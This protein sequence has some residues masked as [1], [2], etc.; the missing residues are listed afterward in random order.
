M[1]D[2]L[3]I[4]WAWLFGLCIG[5]F[6]NVVVYR[7]PRGL[8]LHRPARS[9][10]PCCGRT[11]AWYDNVP[12]LSWLLLGARCRHCQAP[13]SVQYPLVE[14]AT[15]LTFALLAYLLFVAD[16]R[17]GVPAPQLSTDWALLGAWLVLGAGLIA[18]A[19]ID[20]VFYLIDVRITILVCLVGGALYI[21]WPRGELLAATAGTP[22][23]AAAVAAL[24]V[25]LLLWA[26]RS[27]PS[28]EAPPPTD[29]AAPAP[30]SPAEQRAER[31]AGRI[32]ILVLTFISA[33]LAVEA[34]AHGAAGMQAGRLDAAAPGAN[35]AWLACGV[36]PEFVVPA[37]LVAMFTV[38][39]LATGQQRASDLEVAHAIESERP[40]ARRRA[41]R[42]LAWSLPPLAAA[43]VAYW[44]VQ[45]DAAVAR[46]WNQAVGWSPGAG[47]RPLAGLTYAALGLVVGA[48]AGWALRIV[49]TLI[50]GREALGEGDIYILAAAGAAG[51]WDIALL[52]L[53]LAVGIALAGYL[54]TL[55]LKRTTPI[56][57]GPALA[58]GFV[59]ALWLNQRAALLA[60]RYYEDMHFTWHKRPDICLVAAGVMLVGGTVA[61][62]AARLV[63]RAVER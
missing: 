53:M 12:V 41:L 25:S 62:L 30:P 43:V 39:V 23:G 7:M 6:L 54:L 15:G 8:S 17:L 33:W 56:P 27:A 45:H 37:A 26:L 11:I 2:L 35:A 31:I 47:V 16:A 57:F 59:A 14:A 5:S 9:F 34:A 4:T 24:L 36:A 28:E 21:C 38:L 60:Q 49:F 32:G 63:R 10:G 50:F 20:V 58:L 55:A 46:G 40:Q 29:A 19:A 3:L 13:I 48:A 18:C 42:E 51:G 1:T 44:L 52:G 61:V 22:L